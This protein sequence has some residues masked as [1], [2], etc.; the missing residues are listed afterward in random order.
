MQLIEFYNIG[1]AN[2]TI[3]VP[4]R[5]GGQAIY[6]SFHDVELI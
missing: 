4:Q 5:Y 1:I 2:S 6:Y 3:I